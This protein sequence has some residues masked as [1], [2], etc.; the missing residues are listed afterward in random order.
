MEHRL[1]HIGIA[2]GWAKPSTGFTFNRTL[3]FSKMIS[4]ELKSG[5]LASYKPYKNRFLFYDKI[6]LKVL[7]KHNDKGSLIFDEL[8]KK[9]N[10]LL[11]LKFLSEETNL[12]EELKILT[13]FSLKNKILFLRAFLNESSLLF[14]FCKP[15]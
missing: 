13:S 12:L 1:I 3:K 4:D 2:G 6:L 15:R 5:K 11:I 14:P 9:N 7:E 8:F 10:P